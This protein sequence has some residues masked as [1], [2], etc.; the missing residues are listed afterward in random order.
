LRTIEAIAER[1]HAVEVRRA[2]RD[3]LRESSF[4][5]TEGAQQVADTETVFLLHA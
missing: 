2:L 5:N 4:L 1:R 3:L